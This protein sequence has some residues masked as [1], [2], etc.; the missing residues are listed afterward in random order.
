MSNRQNVLTLPL[1]GT[2]YSTTG[3]D[4]PSAY[5]MQW[6][7]EIEKEPLHSNFSY[8]GYLVPTVV[9]MY[10]LHVQYTYMHSIKLRP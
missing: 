6:N 9:R 10:F 1:S 7:F 5:K 3:C 8:P 2:V 4:K